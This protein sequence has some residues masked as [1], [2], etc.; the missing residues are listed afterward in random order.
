MRRAKTYH[1]GSAFWYVPRVRTAETG[2][3]KSLRKI[4][5]CALRRGIILSYL[6]NDN[7]SKA[8]SD[9]NNRSVFDFLIQVLVESS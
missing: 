7:P 2:I 6:L 9:E 3:D 4:S 1:T 8:V 5:P